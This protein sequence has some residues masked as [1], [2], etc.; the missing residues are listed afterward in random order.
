MRQESKIFKLYKD[1]NLIV[2]AMLNPSD[3]TI[4]VDNDRFERSG[5]T[6]K[7]TLELKETKLGDEGYYSCNGIIGNGTAIQLEHY[8]LTIKGKIFQ[9]C[10]DNITVCGKP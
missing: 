7:L 10:L 1:G 5:T 2:T 6:K 8:L 4:S 9:T 3:S